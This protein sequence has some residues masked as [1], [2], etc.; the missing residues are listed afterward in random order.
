MP[1]A[2][3]LNMVRRVTAADF[4]RWTPNIEAWSNWDGT[5]TLA[6]A[7]PIGRR[8]CVTKPNPPYDDCDYFMGIRGNSCKGCCGFLLNRAPAATDFEAV[9]GR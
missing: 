1:E 7:C 9:A 6:S 8:S 4:D 3:S 2:L 5:V